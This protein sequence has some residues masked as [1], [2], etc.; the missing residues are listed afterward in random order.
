VL[1]VTGFTTGA[2]AFLA[3]HGVEVWLWRSAFAPSGDSTPWFLNSGRAVAFTAACL[4]LASAVHAALRRGPQGA[5]GSAV[6]PGLASAAGAWVAMAAV[7]AVL[8]PG[9]I[10]PIVLAAG[11][12][13][14]AAACTAGA[15]LGIRV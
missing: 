15:F 13:I 14:A 8:G 6:A 7:L 9:N 11:A 5:R 3:A 12:L 4:L 1:R 2:A 10:F